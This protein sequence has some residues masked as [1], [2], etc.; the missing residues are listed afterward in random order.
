[1]AVI[2]ALLGACTLPAIEANAPLEP[3]VL[4]L[5]PSETTPSE[6]APVPVEPQTPAPG[7]DG[8]AAAIAA[9]DL[10][11]KLAGL[12]VVTVPGMDPTLHQAFLRRIPASG[13]LLTQSNLAGDT[14]AIRDLISAIHEGSEFPLIMAVDQEGS[15]VARISG[16]QFPGARVL[17]AGSVADT[18]EAFLA[19]QQ[20]VDKAGA[21][22]NF[23]IVADVSGGSGAYIHSRSFSTDPR[24]VA[25]HVVVALGANVDEVA[26]TLK[27]F[28]GH[29]MVFADSHRTIAS[30][31]L[32]YDQWRE[33]HAVPFIAG[34]TAG[35]ELLMTAHI[36]VPAISQDP[37]TLSDDWLAIARNDLGFDGVIIT[38]DLRMLQSSGEDA[39]SDLT[40]V[41]VAALAAGND[42][43]L[44]AVD[45]SVDPELSIYDDVLA[46]L[47]NAVREGVVSEEQ[48]EESLTRVLSL[49]LRLGTP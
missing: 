37:A 35:A 33:S 39:Y 43:L 26:Q 20:L 46:A 9:M 14:F 13:F 16:D 38:D 1:V 45:P 17:G 34:I 10:R 12:L 19:R 25:D 18:A 41:A 32:S 30:S 42:L 31:D 28:P 3:V 4:E 24:V 7:G 11:T 22:V 29:G 23:G 8:V 5:S 40:V 36:R 21:N 47:E 44:M 49:R 2:V 48:V 6:P 15:P 27:H